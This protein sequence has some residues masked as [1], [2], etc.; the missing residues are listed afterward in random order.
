MTVICFLSILNCVVLKYEF[1]RWQTSSCHSVKRLSVPKPKAFMLSFQHS[2]SVI[3]QCRC[4]HSWLILISY[5]S[6][7][8]HCLS[9]KLVPCQWYMDCQQFGVIIST[10]LVIVWELHTW[11][12]TSLLTPPSLPLSPSQTHHLFLN[13]CCYIHICALNTHITGSFSIA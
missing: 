12:L 11:V 3:H 2:V 13:Y 6:V 9:F 4:V 1:C 7:V 10:F 5:F 8:F